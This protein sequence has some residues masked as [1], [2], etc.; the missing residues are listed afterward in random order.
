MAHLVSQSWQLERIA[1]AIFFFNNCVVTVV[2]H[3]L[4]DQTEY[5]FVSV[6]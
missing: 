4:R 5:A 3:Y 1:K 6:V 2:N